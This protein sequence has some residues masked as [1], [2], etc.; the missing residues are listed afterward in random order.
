MYKA[1]YRQYRP[2]TFS[3]LVGQTVIAQTLENALKSNK[4]GHAYLFAG[5]RGTG[6]T[7]VAK[8]FAREIE[9]IPDDNNR[10]S[11]SD[12]IE[13]DAASNNGVD[14]I[15]NLR[16]AANYAPIEYQ[17][18][19]YIIDEVHMLSTG[20]FNALLKTI[21]EPPA[22]VKFILATTEPQKIPATILSRVQRFDFHRI[23]VDQIVKRLEF[24][25]DDQK[26]AYDPAALKIVAN[27]SDGGLRDALSI[28]DQ[29]V[30]ITKTGRVELDDVFKITG[31]SPIDQQI[32][33]LQHVLEKQTAKAFEDIH[34]LLLDGKDP[35][36]FAE[37]LLVL[38]KNLMLIKIAPELVS[39]N[40]FNQIE[41]LS[42]EFSNSVFEQAIDDVSDNLMKMKQTTR[43]ELYLEIL[44][45]KIASRLKK[46]DQK[47]VPAQT[48]SPAKTEMS[49]SA[50]LVNSDASP[51]ESMASDFDNHP[52]AQVDI[53]E[54]N[55]KSNQ[56]PESTEKP[57]SQNEEPLESPSLAKTDDDSAWQVMEAAV[58]SELQAVKDAWPDIVADFD[59]SVVML[60]EN[61][62]PVAASQKGLIISFNHPELAEAAARTP[63]FVAKLSESLLD[64]LGIKYQLV[65]ISEADWV[66]LRKNYI[67]KLRGAKIEDK[68]TQETQLSNSTQSETPEAKAAP[69]ESSENRDVVD[70]AKKLFGDIV[71]VKDENK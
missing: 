2:R 28:L 18:K 34:K 11:F 63:D 62:E 9:G 16:D 53:A 71:K 64:L 45:V 13:I 52:Q 68:S 7:S 65:F 19:I 8:I 3:D 55:E 56:V 42:K 30:A 5:P 47:A 48:P 15:R 57:A 40:A 25:L 26:I 36:R 21:E 10:E 66:T 12:I 27:A 49:S 6:K 69:A 35:I 22:Q 50:A 29:A 31:T 20:A 44:A 43:P 17:F 60:A 59:E 32:G 23:D 39:E 14:E 37:D 46:G 51:A 1:L 70:K 33:F 38:L 24:V 54:K 61:S 41:N 4:V 58:K 67:L